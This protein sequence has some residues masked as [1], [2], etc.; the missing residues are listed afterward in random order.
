MWGSRVRFVWG[1]GV[2]LVALALAVPAG[3]LGACSTGQQTF[4]A[5]GLEQCYVVPADVSALHVVAIG[6]TGGTTFIGTGGSG[7]QV[8]GD[9]AVTAGATL[10]V[11]VGVGGGSG[12]TGGGGESDV[13][14]CSA[15]TSCP[16]PGTPQ[17][18]RLIVAG[19]GGGGGLGGGAG[20]GGS[21]GIGAG[22]PSDACKAASG[23]SAGNLTTGSDGG[24]AGGTCAG[25][26]AGGTGGGER[27]RWDGNHWR[28][29]WRR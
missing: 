16:A 25:G 17:D 19:G 7:A 3:A 27:D 11:E 1:S 29:W 15:S 5:T 14:T 6:G 28:Y 23:G 4:V 9:I 8:T 2:L 26:G 21:A 18:S 20:N 13:R 12:A 22:G 24:G 10:F